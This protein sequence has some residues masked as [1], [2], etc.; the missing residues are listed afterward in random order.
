M[1]RWTPHPHLVNFD[2][3]T[4]IR[5]LPT[6]P[7]AGT[8][9]TRTL[10]QQLA[11]HVRD[12]AE[13]QRALFAHDT[14]AVLLVFQGMDAAGKDSTIRHVLSGVNPAG[15]HV[16]SFKAPSSEA[17]DHDFLWRIS[18]RLPGRGTIGVFNRSHYEEVLVVRVHPEYLQ[19][20]R[21][22]QP[23]LL[24]DIWSRRYRSL[25]SFEQHLADNGT[26]VLK[27]F[28]HVSREEQRQRFLARIDRPEKNWKFNPGD[29]AER[30]RWDD[31]QAA[32][33]QVLRETSR[34]W[35]PWYAI[36]ADNKRY[37]RTTVA[38]IID[39][40]LQRLDPSFPVIDDKRRQELA[41]MRA[42]L[43]GGDLT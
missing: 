27:F 38:Q 22:T 35:A 10:K 18:Q 28:L 40:T 4:R 1:Y 21:L 8:P 11:Q 16:N 2:A 32:Y 33:E 17:L 34:P 19:G 26:T 29:V 9:S 36:P 37:M 30:A 41:A 3:S 12:I 7:P 42:Q 13:R 6:T 39:A 23:E 43:D 14:H 20:A 24:D 15:C 5:D 31:Y 25:R